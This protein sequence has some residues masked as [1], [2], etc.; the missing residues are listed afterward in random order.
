MYKTSDTLLGLIAT[1]SKHEKR[2]FKLHAAFYDKEEGSSILQLFDMIERRKPASGKE[3]LVMAQGEPYSKQFPFVKNQLTEQILDSLSAYHASR[4]SWFTFQRI[5]SH[6]DVLMDRGLRE[7]AKRLLS[8]AEKKARQQEEHWWLVEILHRQRVLT[9][10]HVTPNFE[11][12]IRHV[13]THIRETLGALLSTVQYREI[14]DVIQVLAVRY[15]AMPTKGDSKKMRDIMNSPLLQDEEQALSFNAKLALYS[16]RGTYALLHGD[17]RDALQSYRRAVQL[18]KKNPT[19]LR[20]RLVQ[21]QGHVLNYL[22]CLIESND[23]K[24]FAAVMREAKKL[25]SSGRVANI[26]L[27]DLWNIELLFYIN[28]GKLE[29]CAKTMADVEHFIAENAEEMNPPVLLTLYYNCSAYYFL[30]GKYGKALEYSNAIQN[31]NRIELKRDLQEFAR[32]L[33]L[34]AHYELNNMDILD[35]MIRSAKRFLKKQ[36]TSGGIEHIVLHAF[37]GLLGACDA[38][39]A[40]RVFAAL[41]HKLAT[42]LYQ[43]GEQQPLGLMELLFWSESKMLH[44]PI[45]SLYTNK[46]AARDGA[47]FQELFPLPT[48]LPV[49]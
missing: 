19:L 45:T 9:L 33:S 26:Q 42:Y 35:N 31:E 17:T 44:I 41:Y 14:M 36:K 46:M 30:Q 39:A 43:C 34:I 29:H 6:V 37:V 25:C 5:L 18:W 1:M 27:Q 12:D 4:K 21:Y 7:H 15:A 3:L 28:R 40:Q 22:N 38:D 24:E 10:R 23:E 8:R 11:R 32:V 20:E 47:S 2:Y 16:T 48:E 49:P 13:Y